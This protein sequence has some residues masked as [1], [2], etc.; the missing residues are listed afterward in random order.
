MTPDVLKVPKT[1][2][3]TVGKR[4]RMRRLSSG[5]SQSDLAK[6]IGVSFQQVQKYE[7]G[8]NRVSA[9]RLQQIAAR[10]GVPVSFFFEGTEIEQPGIVPN[11]DHALL[12]DMLTTS[13]GIALVRA[14]AA[15]KDR[16][17]RA[18]AVALLQSIAAATGWET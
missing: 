9:S 12:M 7:K 8:T 2:D 10:L 4:I 18:K 15:I 3:V 13:D 14:Y 5:I 16:N 17:I 1:T 11:S 6:Q